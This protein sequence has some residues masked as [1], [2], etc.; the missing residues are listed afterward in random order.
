MERRKTVRYRISLPVEMENGSGRT[1]DIG[2][3]GVFFETDQ[4]AVL[5]RVIPFSIMLAHA[6]PGTP[7]RFRGE[8]PIV[9][10]EERSSTTGV[11]AALSAIRLEPC[12]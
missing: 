12:E 6:C 8:G 2:Q 10:I 11:A 4:P 5:G 1:R 9:R 7:F 3:S